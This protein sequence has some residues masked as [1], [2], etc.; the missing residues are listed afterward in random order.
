MNNIIIFNFTYVKL[1]MS[2]SFIVIIII[3]V[4]ITIYYLFLRKDEAFSWH[5][6]FP[7]W[8]NVNNYTP[9]SINPF[10]WNPYLANSINYNP[11]NYDYNIGYNPFYTTQI[12]PNYPYDYYGATSVLPYMYNNSNQIPYGINCYSSSKDAN[13][14]PG[15]SK[16]GRDIGI[17]TF[18]RRSR[19]DVSSNSNKNKKIFDWQCCRL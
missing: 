6:G 10:L 9:P 1:K 17:S 7:S 15:F 4:I 11:I 5:F 12:R 16:I 2:W 13:C 19:S 8:G 18:D 3:I 14:V